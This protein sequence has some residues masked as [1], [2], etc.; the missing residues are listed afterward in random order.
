VSYY[1]SKKKKKKKKHQNRQPR[2]F[3][4]REMSDHSFLTFHKIMLVM[5]QLFYVT[6]AISKPP[7][8][9]LRWIAE[10][11]CN[12]K[13]YASIAGPHIA[14]MQ[15]EY[16]EALSKGRTNKAR[17]I[18]IRDSVRLFYVLGVYRALKTI[19]GLFSHPKMPQ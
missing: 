14:D 2:L 18:R 15:H 3:D 13:T 11:F 4:T 9:F 16:F 12:E 8:G 5:M 6:N 1:K 17:W 19:A 10:F 7:G